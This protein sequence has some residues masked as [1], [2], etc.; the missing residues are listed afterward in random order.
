L[1]I[2]STPKDFSIPPTL[3]LRTFRVCNIDVRSSSWCLIYSLKSVFSRCISC[4]LAI[5]SVNS[6]TFSS[7]IFFSLS[8]CPFKRSI[9]LGSCPSFYLIWVYSSVISLSLVVPYSFR[10]SSY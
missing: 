10:D 4:S 3:S 6:L 7:T 5:D 1:F 9:C 2:T 8:Y